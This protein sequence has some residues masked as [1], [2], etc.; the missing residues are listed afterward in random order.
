MITS[1][2][3]GGNFDALDFGDEPGHDSGAA[4]DFG[5]ESG[6]DSGA[7]LDFGDDSGAD[8]A[9]QSAIDTVLIDESAVLADTGTE[10]RATD[11]LPEDAGAA[12]DTH[13]A[14]DEFPPHL[15]TVTNPPE[16]VSVTASV[17]GTIRNVE[18][19]MD[20]ARM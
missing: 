11:V 18:L 20:A 9:D 7:A 16:T 1:G 10:Q 17:D 13:A 15:T 5:D 4:L 19:S 2:N 12:G 6:H 3:A 8:N 14:D